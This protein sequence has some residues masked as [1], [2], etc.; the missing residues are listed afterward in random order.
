MK[1]MDIQ[2][3]IVE[4]VC[5]TFM[6][7]EEEIVLD[8]SLVDQGIIDSFGLMEIAVHLRKQFAIETEQSE[9]TRDNFGSL[10][11]I[12][13]YVERKLQDEELQVR[14]FTRSS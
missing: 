14:S 11:R 12:A 7:D 6:V 5:R 13:A 10:L 2:R 9:I 4:F 8:R 3:D 1:R